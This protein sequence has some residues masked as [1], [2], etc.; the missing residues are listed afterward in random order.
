MST[1]HAALT[2]PANAPHDVLVSRIADV[3]A[4][5]LADLTA[6]VADTAELLA[7][8]APEVELPVAAFNSTI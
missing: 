3:R 6:A 7:R 8:K 1:A 2:R 4:A 5:P